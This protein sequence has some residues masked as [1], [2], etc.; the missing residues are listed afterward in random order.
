M[1]T[2]GTD[3]RRKAAAAAASKAPFGRR[4]NVV[5]H[6]CD[7]VRLGDFIAQPSTAWCELA[8]SWDRLPADAYVKASHPGRFR[9]YGRFAYDPRAAAL[10]PLAH[11]PFFQPLELNAYAGG[12]QRDFA[13]LEQS[14]IEN[15]IIQT[16]LHASVAA[17]ID[18]D[19]PRDWEIGVHQIR[20]IGRADLA[21]EPAPEGMHRDGFDFISIHLVNRD[22]VEGGETILQVDDVE[23]RVLLLEP[24]DTVF[25]DD[26]RCL[27]G[28]TAIRPTVPDRD[29]TR[30]TLIVTFHHMGA[31]ELGA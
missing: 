29:A 6:G 24:L 30:D 7:H 18:A 14:T 3:T 11:R 25:L 1:D 13:P 16:T 19:D 20:V 2:Y 10:V 5:V 21:G 9:R 23:A 27:H 12:I 4:T 15:S 28:V 8:S 26:T 31:R 17:F 22:N